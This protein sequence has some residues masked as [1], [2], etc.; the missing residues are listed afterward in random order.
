MIMARIHKGEGDNWQIQG[1]GLP[2]EGRSFAELIPVMQQN[3]KETLHPELDILP[4]PT[5][6]VMTKVI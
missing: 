1:L 3:L 6:V 4:L 5:Y 2:G